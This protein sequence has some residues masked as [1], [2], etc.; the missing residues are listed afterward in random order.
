[1]FLIAAAGAPWQGIAIAGPM[2]P[3]DELN[4]LHARAARAKVILHTFIPRL[5]TLFHS[6]DALVCMGGYNTLAEAA[7]CAVP[8]VCVPRVAPRSE[9][10]I[11]AQAF[12][13]LGILHLLHP[14][15]LNPPALGATIQA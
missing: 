13:R 9:Q 7:L 11:R 10:L 4:L 3:D 12:E 5:S 14:R 15:D 6:L 8:A 1:N 2:T